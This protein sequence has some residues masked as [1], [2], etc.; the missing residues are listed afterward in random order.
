MILRPTV[1]NN[2]SVANEMTKICGGL[3]RCDLRRGG[4]VDR[5]QSC[6]SVADRLVRRIDTNR[7]C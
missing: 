7:K 4:S 1:P 5:R 2:T 3:S 6:R